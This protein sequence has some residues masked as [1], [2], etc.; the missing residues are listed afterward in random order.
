MERPAAWPYSSANRWNEATVR[1]RRRAVEAKRIG[2]RFRWL[3]LHLRSDLKT[4]QAFGEGLGPPVTGATVSNWEQGK[5]ISDTSKFSIC[6][7]IGC[8]I[9]DFYAWPADAPLR[10]NKTFLDD[11]QL[12][13]DRERPP[14]SDHNVGLE[15]T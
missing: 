11:I 5:P 6:K 12:S 13:P 2:L 15:Y 8:D 1:K 7:L 14:E 10:R 9:E 3:R 4:Q